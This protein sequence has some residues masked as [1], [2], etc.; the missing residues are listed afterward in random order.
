LALRRIWIE[1][2]RIKDGSRVSVAPGDYQGILIA[3]T[4]VGYI[5]LP[6][7]DNAELEALSRVCQEEQRWE[8]FLTAAPWRFRGTTS[9]PVNPL[10]IF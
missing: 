3:K 4:Q 5:G 7:L 10:A 8:F 9:S 1:S 6:L 2:I